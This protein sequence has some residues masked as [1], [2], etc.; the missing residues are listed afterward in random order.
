MKRY[1]PEQIVALLWHIKVEIASII[2]THQP[3]STRRCF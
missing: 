1:K 2:L 3:L